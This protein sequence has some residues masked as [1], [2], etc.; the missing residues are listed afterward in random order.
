MVKKLLAACVGALLIL[1]C[2]PAVA[3]ETSGGVIDFTP[4]VNELALAVAT[5][6]SAALLYLAKLARDWFKA[7][8]GV[9]LQI[10]DAQMR[11]VLDKIR[12]RYVQARLPTARVMTVTFAGRYSAVI[13]CVASMR[14]PRR[15]RI[16]R[17][18]WSVMPPGYLRWR[19]WAV[20]MGRP[21]ATASPTSTLGVT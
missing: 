12:A 20:P 21:M 5:V 2:A 4:I 7:R 1:V 11:A 17:C 16:S 6:A 15:S 9:E 13:T 19:E 8:T 3:Q 14:P 10:S 18:T